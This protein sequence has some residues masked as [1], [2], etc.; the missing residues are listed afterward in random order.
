MKKDLIKKKNGGRRGLA[1]FCSLALALSL[2]AG[3]GNGS[4]EGGT[5]EAGAAETENVSSQTDADM[6]TDRDYRTDYAEEDSVLIQ[7]NGTSV[8]ASSDSVVI[9]GSTI[10]ITEEATYILSGTLED[11]MVIVDAPDTAKLQ[12]VLNEASIHSETSAP[13]YIREADKVFVT[14]AEGSENTLSIGGTFTVDAADDGVHSNASITIAG[15]TITI[16]TG[17]DG[18]HADESLTVTGGTLEVTESYEGLEALHVSIE[19]GDI[20]VVSSDDGLNAAG[21]ADSSGTTGGRDGQFG[22]DRGGFGGT[23][24]SSGSI[25]ISGGELYIRA[26]GDGIDANGS[27][28]ISGGTTVVTGPTRGDT[29]TLDY[30]TTAEITGGTF[31]GTGASGDVYKRQPLRVGQPAEGVR[32]KAYKRVL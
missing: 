9:S 17:D 27:L 13:L 15:G 18:F 28:A 1:L 7:L 24:S 31:I 32:F 16:A 30:D 11:G 22:G 3:C 14:L 2:A 19:G 21:G 26:S 5:S 20:S 4:G 25:D 10:T 29:A 6:F 23:G 8:T 12:L